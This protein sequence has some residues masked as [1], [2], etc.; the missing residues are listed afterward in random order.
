MEQREVVLMWLARHM[1]LY[2]GDKGMGCF[3]PVRYFERNP[4]IG[5]QVLLALGTK[6]NVTDGVSQR[7]CMGYRNHGCWI[8]CGD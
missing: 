7:S 4:K 1:A 5:G 6:Q 8:G 3:T 2:G